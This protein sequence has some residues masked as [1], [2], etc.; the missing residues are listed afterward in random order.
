MEFRASSFGLSVCWNWILKHVSLSVCWQNKNKISKTSTV[1]NNF[2]H[3]G[4]TLSFMFDVCAIND[5]VIFIPEIAN[6]EFLPSR[7]PCLHIFIFKILA[8]SCH[9]CVRLYVYLAVQATC[10]W[11]RQIDIFINL[12]CLNLW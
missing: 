9:G 8:N 5:P 6:L 1:G 4:L 11:L 12:P 7:H 3:K 2:Y 10:R